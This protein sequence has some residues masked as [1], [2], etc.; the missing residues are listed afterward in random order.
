MVEETRPIL[1]YIKETQSS[2]LQLM[3]NEFKI[4]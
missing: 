2:W 3:L 1:V 4:E